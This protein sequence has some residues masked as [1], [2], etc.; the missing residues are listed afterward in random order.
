MKRANILRIAF[1][2]AIAFGLVF[3]QPVVT[4]AGAGGAAA[5]AEAA[6]VAGEAASPVVVEAAAA[7]SPTCAARHDGTDRQDAVARQREL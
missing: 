1:G 5:T 7:N 2:V 6:L 3:D 4:G